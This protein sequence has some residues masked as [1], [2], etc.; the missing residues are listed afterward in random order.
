[1]ERVAP[2]SERPSATLLIQIGGGIMKSTGIF[3]SLALLFVWISMAD[4]AA[5]ATAQITGTVRDQSGAVLPGVEISVTQ[6]ET[7]IMRTTVSNETG[8]FVLP[9]LALGS[10]RL[11]ASLP[12]FRTYVQTGIE[13]Q[14]NSSPA[15]N[16]LLQVG[17][18]SDSI[19]VQA[20]AAMVETRTVGISQVMETQRILELPLNGRTVESLL[21]LNG[22]AVDGGSM[23]NR[24]LGGQRVSMGGGLAFGV[25]YKLDGANHMNYTSTSG[26]ALPFPDALQEFDVRTSGLTAE[27]GT[28]SAVAAVTKSGT[29]EFHGDAFD[30]VRNDLFNA[31][32]YFAIKNSTL[33]RNQFGG[34][35]GGPIRQGKLFFFAGYQETTIRQDPANV[36]AFLP[37][38]AML[39]GDWTTVASTQCQSRALTLRAPLVGNRI[40]PRLFSPAAVNVIKKLPKTD[41]ACGLITYG[42]RTI[43]NNGQG[44]GRIDYKQSD[45]HSLFGR[46]MVTGER[47]PS[48]WK[49]DPSNI[50]LVG[51]ITNSNLGT[52]IAVGSTYLIGSTMVNSFRAAYN[53]EMLGRYG[54]EWFSACDM[55]VNIYCGYTPKHMSLTI[56]GGF[57]L[58]QTSKPNDFLF[59]KAYDASDDI[60][61]VRGT[62]QLSFGGGVNHTYHLALTSSLAAG[63]FNFTGE[64]TGAGLGDFM[65]GQLSTFQQGF[66]QRHEPQRWYP[67]AY[68][69]DT[70]KATPSLTLNYGLRWEPYLPEQRLSGDAYNFDYSRFQQGIKSTVYLKAPAG[71]YYPGDP[72]FPN[73]RAG[74]YKQWS[75]FSPRVGL[76]WTLTADGRTSVRSSY[77]YSY[78]IVGMEFS[79]ELGT[80][81][82]FGGRVQVTAPPGGFDDPWRGVPGYNLAP[83]VLDKNITFGPFGLFISQPY[84]QKVP[85]TSTWNV[86]IQRQI[87]TNSILSATY[88]ASITTQIPGQEALNPSIYIP[89][90]PCVLPDGKTYNPCSTSATSDLRRKL[91]LE[92]YADGQFIGQ[93]MDETAQGTQRYGGLL[94]GL[95]TRPAAGVN[96]NTNYTWS[97]C[98]G[99]YNTSL[100]T[101]GPRASQTYNIRGNRRYDWGNCD[102]DRRQIFNLTAVLESPRF[103]NPAMRAIGTG[104]RLAPIYRLSSGSPLTVTLGQ[105]LALNGGTGDLLQ[106][107]NQILGDVYGPVEPLQLYLNPNAFAVPA[108]ATYGNMGRNSIR[109]P[110]TWSFDLALSR[111]FTLREKQRLEFRGEAYNVTNSFRPQ[112]PNTVLNNRTFGQLRTAFDPRILQFA[113][114]FVF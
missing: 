21:L 55:G 107:P 47:K 28:G 37:T 53:R 87:S 24:A 8:S 94:M 111:S 114:K 10:Y 92:R 95:Q 108:I 85:R 83:V 26:N 84:N 93:L 58:N 25:D 98:V 56:T 68:V 18:V 38:A 82:P 48:A 101:A 40:D 106:R 105:D 112:N 30:F 73:E 88:L 35:I 11:E 45:R 79:G 3:L 75:Q 23:T 64:F 52:S 70:W 12:G 4:A 15:I 81:P 16:V 13:L 65:T 39:A 31:R 43:N 71:F 49:S 5:Q 91:S 86:S 22:G 36:Q 74:Q 66:T 60:S 54:N 77:G 109:G 27:I 46:Y 32:N 72:G 80:A 7:G 6:I 19:E 61:L 2:R 104:W 110:A 97:H 33:K 44:I 100:K 99:D 89:G 41:D 59:T 113:L 62:H 69:T 78:E 102:T 57:N 42:Q 50:L 63:V 34:T 14:V 103:V 29:N 20:N 90:G 9:S 1:M 76:A 67:R 96:I 17:Q 51:D